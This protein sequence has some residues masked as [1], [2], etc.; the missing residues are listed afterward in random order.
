MNP[1]EVVRHTLRQHGALPMVKRYSR[2]NGAHTHI[3]AA[4]ALLG[5]PPMAKRANTL[6]SMVAKG[7]IEPPTQGFS[8]LCSTN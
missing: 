2:Q 6:N 7:G 4:M 8:V 1:D 3:Q 5:T